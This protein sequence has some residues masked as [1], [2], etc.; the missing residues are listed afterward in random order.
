[1]IEFCSVTLKHIPGR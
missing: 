1:M